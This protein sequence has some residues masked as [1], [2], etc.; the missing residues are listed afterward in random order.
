MHHVFHLTKDC[1]IK[2]G[3]AII[4]LAE[5]RTMTVVIL[6][7]ACFL[8]RCSLLLYVFLP[9]F[10]FHGLPYSVYQCGALIDLINYYLSR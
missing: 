5:R 2:R 1:S 8:A 4:T 9:S 3:L 7:P 10:I 6:L